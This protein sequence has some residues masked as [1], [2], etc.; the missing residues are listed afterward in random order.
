MFCCVAQ[1]W[2]VLPVVGSHLA[3]ER[4][5]YH[6]CIREADCAGLFVQV[7]HSSCYWYGPQGSSCHLVAPPVVALGPERATRSQPG[8]HS[9]YMVQE[10]R[11]QQCAILY[12]SG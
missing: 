2:A 3:Q 10:V 8:V 4:A 5:C 9:Y 7:W 12:F 11:G 6:I 1:V